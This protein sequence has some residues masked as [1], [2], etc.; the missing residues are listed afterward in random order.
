MSAGF[1]QVSLALG[2]CWYPVWVPINDPDLSLFFPPTVHYV[3]SVQ[4]SF[5]F[6]LSPDRDCKTKLNQ[7]VS[8]SAQLFSSDFEICSQR[9]FSEFTWLTNDISQIFYNWINTFAFSHFWSLRCVKDYLKYCIW[10]KNHN[11]FLLFWQLHKPKGT[12]KPIPGWRFWTQNADG[13]KELKKTKLENMHLLKKCSV[14]A[15]YLGWIV[16]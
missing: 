10:N 8:S 1:Q 15:K 2:D 5:Q 14:N 12:I 16:K 7:N 6:T 4:N 11:T 3:K 9:S 13:V